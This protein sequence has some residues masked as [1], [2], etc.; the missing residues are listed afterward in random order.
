MIHVQPYEEFQK[1]PIYQFRLLVIG[2]YPSKEI[3]GHIIFTTFCKPVKK[4]DVSCVPFE[5]SIKNEMF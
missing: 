3:N 1:F 5:S 4:W 2:I